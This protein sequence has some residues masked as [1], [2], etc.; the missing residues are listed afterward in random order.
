[1]TSSIG[2]AWS[3]RFRRSW[4]EDHFHEVGLAA[5]Q[6][7]EPAW[8]VLERGDSGDER[9]DLALAALA[10]YRWYVANPPPFDFDSAIQFGAIGG[11]S[12]LIGLVARYISA[13]R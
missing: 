3:L 12:F 8:T 10:V 2:S 7:L 11:G 9:L 6:A 13:G 5:V 4:R 1:M